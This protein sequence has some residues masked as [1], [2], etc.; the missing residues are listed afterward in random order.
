MLPLQ[1]LVRRQL[2]FNENF[3]NQN[4]IFMKTK[5]LILLCM[6]LISNFGFTQYTITYSNHAPQVGDIITLSNVTEYIDL[7]PGNAGGNQTWDFSAYPASGLSE[8]YYE[9]PE[10][11]LWAGQVGDC[12]MA[13]VG[14]SK[15]QTVLYYKISPNDQRLKFV[16][17]D[18]SGFQ[19][20]SEY[21]N[22]YLEMVFPFGFNDAFTD[23]IA[24]TIDYSQIGYNML[25]SAWSEL[26]VLAEGWGTLIT[27]EQEFT[28]VL[29]VKYTINEAWKTYAEGILVDS[30]EWTETAYHW[31]CA[32]SKHSV[33]RVSVLDDG[34]DPITTI[35]Y[36]SSAVGIG[37]HNDA[38]FAISPNPASESFR[39]KDIPDNIKTIALFD[40]SGRQVADHSVNALS[41]V[42]SCAD[43]PAG[44]YF[45]TLFDENKEPVS[46]GKIVISH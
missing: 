36:G 45:V 24:Y 43:V 38:S 41:G 12:N 13:L 40:Y 26:T 10:N 2:S 28:D 4:K 6:L 18:Y 33:A 19:T 46:V 32:G 30:G 20:L 9:A 22:D 7:D 31:Y 15:D 17:T 1:N 3:K 23:D 21:W 11:T 34:Q 35:Q 29:R 42:F 5:L 8:Y 25:D 16:G 39:I 44:L 14:E 37:D 27:P